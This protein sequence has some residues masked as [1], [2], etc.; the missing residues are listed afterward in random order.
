MSKWYNRLGGEIK[1]FRV[2]RKVDKMF[3]RSVNNPKQKK[4][5]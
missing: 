1:K 5:K 2:Q 4:K 3:D